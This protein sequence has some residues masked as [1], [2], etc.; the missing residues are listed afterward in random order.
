MS[1]LSISTWSLHRELGPLHWNVWNGDE[2]K[3]QVRTEEQPENIKLVDL[4][5]TLDAQGFGAVEICHFHFQRTD[6]AYLEQ[7]KSAFAMTDIEFHTLLIDYGDI[8]SPDEIRRSADVNFIKKWIRIASIVGAKRVRVIT[9]KANPEDRE[10]LVRVSNHLNEL[11]D[12]A[13]SFGVHVNTENFQA[14]TSDVE[15]CIYLIEHSQHHLKL[16]TD[17]GNFS[18]VTKYDDLE[19]IL[20]YSDSIHAKAQFDD[21]GIPNG[22]EFRKCL[23]LL[24]KVKYNGPI[25]LIYDGPGD[26]WAGINRV[27]KIVESYL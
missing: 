14:L 21:R 16:I 9:G 8:S 12:Y 26:M 18:G 19:K 7:L 13:K 25:T 11:A 10:A 3:I 23:D 1:Y 15:N 20:P 5:A 4:P 27:R 6:R 22:Q 24:S 2:K 17:F